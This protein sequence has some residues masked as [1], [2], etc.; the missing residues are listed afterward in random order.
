MVELLYL[1]LLFESRKVFCSLVNSGSTLLT[2]TNSSNWFLY[3]S[4][5]GLKLREFD[6]RSKHFLLGEN[7][8]NSKNLIS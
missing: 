6:K 3:I 2:L 7:F 4:L 5:K 8:I 1:K